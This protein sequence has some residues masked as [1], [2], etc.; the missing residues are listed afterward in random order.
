MSRSA[1]TKAYVQPAQ[2]S[3]RQRDG[4]AERDFDFARRR[5]GSEAAGEQK[6]LTPGV[7]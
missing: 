3:L 7:D 2:L 4:L 5:D 1:F 6:K